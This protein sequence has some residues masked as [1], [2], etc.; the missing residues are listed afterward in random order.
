MKTSKKSDKSEAVS[1]TIE[2][3]ITA[4][5]LLNSFYDEQIFNILIKDFFNSNME[6]SLAAIKASASLGNEAA[7]PHL[8][9]IIEKGKP[10]QKN[11]AI[12]TLTKIIKSYRVLPQPVA[13]YFSMRAR[14]SASNRSSA[15]RVSCVGT[16][17][18][19]YPFS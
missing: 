13:P 2:T 7:I 15:A 9:T 14:V 16:P 11:A 3:R 5:T 10:V 19:S 18:R 8:C 17:L 6:V 1:T 12:Q 4:L